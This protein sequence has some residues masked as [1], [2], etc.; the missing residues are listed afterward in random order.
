MPYRPCPLG[1]HAVVLGPP[2]NRRQAMFDR[3][4]L[5]F[6]EDIMADRYDRWPI[7]ASVHHKGDGHSVGSMQRCEN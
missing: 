3:L 7:L 5:G 4:D 2:V 1:G 6:S